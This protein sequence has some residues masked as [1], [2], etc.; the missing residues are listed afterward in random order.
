MNSTLFYIYLKQIPENDHIITE[1]CLVLCSINSN[2]HPSK[3]ETDRV[4]VIGAVRINFAKFVLLYA[5]FTHF[6]HLEAQ[7]KLTKTVSTP[8]YSETL[9]ITLSQLK[10]HTFQQG[11]LY[12][13]H[14]CSPYP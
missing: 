14:L 6:F 13:Q 4:P 12:E 1:T 5:S 3:S 10:F 2:L 11:W 7:R 8:K 9:A